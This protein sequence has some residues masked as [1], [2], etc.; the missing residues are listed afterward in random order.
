MDD[1]WLNRES[2]I[3]AAT[4]FR[5]PFYCY[6]AQ[7]LNNN[8]QLLRNALP[9][10]VDIFYSIKANPNIAICQEL[11]YLGA[12]AELCS[13]YE[14]YAALHAGF[15]AENII[16]VGPAKSNRE[17][18]K[19]IELDVYAIICESITEYQRISDIAKQYGKVA[20]VAL[21]INP[22]HS[23]KTALLKMGGKA[24]QFGMDEEIIFQNRDYFLMMPN[25]E[26]VGIHIYNGTRIL[27]ASTIVE[28]TSYILNLARYIQKEWQ[29][30]FKM[31]DI[32]GGLGVPYYE[33][34]QELNLK[35]LSSGLRPLVG[36]Y[37]NDFPNTRIILESG[38]YLTAKAGIFISQVVDIKTSKNEHFIITDGGS[39]CHMA[40]SGMGSLIKRNFPIEILRQNQEIEHAKL[41]IQ[42]YN[43]TGPLCTPG[44][45]IGK[46]VTLPKI[47]IGD[48]VIVKN[49]GAYGPTAS[50]VMFLSHGFPAEI[51]LKN[52]Q[53]HLIR[54][55]FSEP[56]FMD[57][58]Y[59]INT[60]GESK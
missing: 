14:I 33:G 18:E 43:I 30:R 11:G 6:S 24:S 5:T 29:V 48:F 60:Q 2:L 58:Q 20:R 3:D 42:T 54:E 46:Q 31:V 40:A 59:L 38:R 52:N 25:I 7:S 9:S 55:R 36:N 32:G 57:N 37:Q 4:K 49:S 1:V 13:L 12:C 45:L 44:D 8:F 41:P 16:F 34:E 21:R 26:L 53:F 10:S 17:I 51:L 27:T 15:K 19:C 35:A 47:S 56:H 50:P 39:N 23:S 22:S 28:N